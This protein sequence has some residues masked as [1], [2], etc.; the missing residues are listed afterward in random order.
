MFVNNAKLG[1]VLLI[2]I[3][4]CRQRIQSIEEMIDEVSR[5]IKAHDAELRKR[6]EALKRN[7]KVPMLQNTYNRGVE[8]C[9]KILG[10]E[11]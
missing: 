3:I 5:A 10:F 6:M 7:G 9:L 1:S 2:G 11:E 8:V 4:I